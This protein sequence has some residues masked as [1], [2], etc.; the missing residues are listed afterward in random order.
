MGESKRICLWKT[1]TEMGLLDHLTCLLI[2]L[3][4]SQEGR[5]GTLYGT[6]DWFR[7]EKG[8]QHNCLLSSCLFNLYAEHIMWN[9]RLNE[10]Q[11]GI[12]MTY[13]HRERG[14]EGE[15]YGNSN[16]DTY[17]TICKTDSQWEFTVSLRKLK[18]GLCISLGEWDGEADGREV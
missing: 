5:V 8:V 7:F 12:K 14:G 17:I 4:V 11:A 2:N 6:T 1:L 10:L 3:Y 18:E 13:G 9:T 15:M 16:R